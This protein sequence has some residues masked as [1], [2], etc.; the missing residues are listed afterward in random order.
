MSIIKETVN[1]RAMNTLDARQISK[2]GTV[3]HFPM[4]TEMPKNSDTVFSIKSGM[5]LN[6]KYEI[7]E[8]IGRGGTF[9]VFLT[10]DHALI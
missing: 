2:S 1:K 8:Q 9:D 5:I 4:R 3:M 7:I 10:K 6:D